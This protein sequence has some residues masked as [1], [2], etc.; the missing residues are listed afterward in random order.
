MVSEILDSLSYIGEKADISTGAI[1]TK[2][3]QKYE[4]R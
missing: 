3:H 2:E 4:D 1:V